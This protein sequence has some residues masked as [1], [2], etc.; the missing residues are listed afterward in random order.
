[1]RQADHEAPVAFKEVAEEAVVVRLAIHHMHH[2]RVTE[3]LVGAIDAT[4]PA[5]TFV[6]FLFATHPTVQR[7]NAERSSLDV[8]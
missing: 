4:Q 5:C 3:T 8:V 2:S 7:R 6:D 1:M